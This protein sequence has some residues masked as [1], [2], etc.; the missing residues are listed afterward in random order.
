MIARIAVRDRGRR[1]RDLRGGGWPHHFGSLLRDTCVDPKLVER[2]AERVLPI[3]QR[4]S[5]GLERGGLGGVSV[6]DGLVE[7]GDLLIERR[8][9]HLDL[10]ARLLEAG[11][12]LLGLHLR[13]GLDVRVHQLGSG[14]WVAAFNADGH[15]VGVGSSRSVHLRRIGG[16]SEVLLHLGEHDLTLEHRDLVLDHSIGITG[17]PARRC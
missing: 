7:I 11:N 12:R 1:K 6:V 5:L 9:A 2:L 4:P 10:F 14:L 16:D 13:V 3:E 8:E 15:D 17:Q